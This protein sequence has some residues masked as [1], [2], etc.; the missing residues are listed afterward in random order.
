MASYKY[1][2]ART[3]KD[4]ATSYDFLK[5]SEGGASV[6]DDDFWNDAKD[7]ATVDTTEKVKGKV[8]LF[9]RIRQC[10]LPVIDF[11]RPLPSTSQRST[12][13]PTGDDQEFPVDLDFTTTS[14]AEREIKSLYVQ[15]RAGATLLCA[16]SLFFGCWAVLNTRAM[17][18]GQDLGMYSF[19]TTFISSHY[20]L[21]RTRKSSPSSSDNQ[22]VV[23]TPLTR[24]LVSASHVLVFLNYCLGILF[25]YTVGS[26]SY[27]IFGVYCIIFAGL[28]GYVAYRGVVLL[29]MLQKHENEVARRADDVEHLDEDGYF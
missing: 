14:N 16:V 5:R 21:C 8:S 7:D 15:L 1:E 26:H 29:S 3:R 12:N 23:A 4:D 20:L 18:N 2:K 6:G 28:W 19:S 17:E 10:I 22:V 13:G 24:L 27:H 9:R 25:A 11:Y